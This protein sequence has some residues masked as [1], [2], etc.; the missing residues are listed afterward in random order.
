[1]FQIP[2][3]EEV[4]DADNKAFNGDL[5]SDAATS[6]SSASLTRPDANNDKS[7]DGEIP[8]SLIYLDSQCDRHRLQ[9]LLYSLHD[10][11]DKKLVSSLYNIGQ[12]HGLRRLCRIINE[13]V[14]SRA[15]SD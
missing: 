11:R 14:P 4:V 9:C 5:K 2:V 12:R 10:V 6:E 1:M 3:A 15:G 8:R 13:T 7:V